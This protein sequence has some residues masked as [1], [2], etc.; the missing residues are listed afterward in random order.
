M[1]M[2]DDSCQ[3]RRRVGSSSSP[4][5]RAILFGAGILG[6]VAALVILE[7][8]RRRK[9]KADQNHRL[10]LFQI[11][12]TAL[13]VTDLAWT[14][15]VS[16]LMLLSHSQNTSLVGMSPE[17]HSVCAYFGF[18]MTFFSLAT[19]FLLFSMAIERC[20]A[21][22]FPLFYSSHATRKCAFITVPAVF[23]LSAVFCLL[24]FC[25]FGKYVQYC[26]GTWCF[27]DMNPQ[28]K[29]DRVYA[30]LYATVVLVLVLAIVA[31]N[32][33]VVYRLLRLYRRRRNPAGERRETAMAEVVE[34]LL[35]LVFMT[36]IFLICTM[37]LDCFCIYCDTN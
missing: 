4:L 7:I 13:L 24:P 11:F 18:S 3:E 10:P 36:I 20:V 22:G 32:L 19:M 15:L 2:S 6:N 26:P 5:I 16:P 33:F 34:Y 25:G 29:E 35:L 37:F 30:L 31:S 23:L 8:R 14:C 12:I 21:I 9:S 28:G 1:F 27:I 17:S